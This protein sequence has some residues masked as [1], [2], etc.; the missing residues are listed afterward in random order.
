M[1]DLRNPATVGRIE[2][3]TTRR[4]DVEGTTVLLIH[5]A[6]AR[7][8]MCEAETAAR[9]YRLARSMTAGRTWT[10]LARFALRRAERARTEVDGPM[11]R[12]R[13]FPIT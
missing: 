7:S 6:L 1:T 13:V 10:A 2:L 9:D 8:R 3:S 5:E 11:G 12:G 4:T